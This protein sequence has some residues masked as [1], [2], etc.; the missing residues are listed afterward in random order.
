MEVRHAPVLLGRLTDA[1][2]SLTAV[3]LLGTYAVGMAFSTR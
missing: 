2:L 1:W 3:C